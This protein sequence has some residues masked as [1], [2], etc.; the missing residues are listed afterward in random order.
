[1]DDADGMYQ[2]WASDAEVTRF[3]TWPPHGSP[4]VTKMLLTDWISHYEEKDFYQWAIT[5]K[6]N[7]DLPI[8]NI[9]VVSK[10]DSIPKAQVGYCIGKAWWRRGIMTE[11][12]RAVLDF[13]FDEVGYFRVEAYHDARNPHSGAVMKKCG[14]QYEGTL[15]QAE[16][17]NQG[18]CD[19]CYY[20]LLK[21]DR[22]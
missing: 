17:N 21:T 14:M 1:M 19:V 10:E 18:V 22:P 11:A 15:R 9:A 2:N 16:R 12:L 7:G 5:L 6:E 4:S 13:L 8:G 20:A 3:L